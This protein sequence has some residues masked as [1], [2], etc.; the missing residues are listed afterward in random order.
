MYF[1]Q[2]IISCSFLFS[3]FSVV[4]YSPSWVTSQ[5]V[6]AASKKV[7]DGDTCSCVTGNSSTPTSTFPFPNAFPSTPNLGYGMSNYQGISF[8]TSNR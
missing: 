4:T 8:I 2:V 7:I 6:Q 1:V 3:V 5:Y